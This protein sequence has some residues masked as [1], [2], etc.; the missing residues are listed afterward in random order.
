M[1]WI[2]TLAVSAGLLK[3][4]EARD[5]SSP[6]TNG[7][8]PDTLWSCHGLG[9]HRCLLIFQRWRDNRCMLVLSAMKGQE[10]HAGHVS[11]E[12]TT[13]ACW[14]CRRMRSRR[15]M[16]VLLAM[17]RNQIHPGLVTGR[18]ARGTAGLVTD[19]EAADRCWSCQRW[20]GTR[21]TLALSQ[22]ERQEVHADRNGYT[23]ERQHIHSG[24]FMD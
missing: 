24:L 7:E 8:E 14:S 9:G 15:Y 6:V 11:D 13:D 3:E 12:R 23:I 1:S 4:L 19:G 20:R 18:E 2:R 10:M 16:L 5:N 17:K 22:I 21:Y